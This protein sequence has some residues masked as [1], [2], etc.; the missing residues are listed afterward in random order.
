M[1]DRYSRQERFG[2]IGTPG[3]EALGSAKA[4]ICG[5]GA[6][7]TAGAELLVRAGVGHVVLIDRDY[8]ELSNLQRQFLFTEEDARQALPKAVAAERHLRLRNSA[9]RVTGIVDDLCSQNA[10]D[11][12]EG[13]NLI[14]DATDNFETRYLINDYSVEQGM[15]WI[16]AAAVGSYGITMPIIPELTPCF[17]CIYPQ[18]PSGTQPTCETAGVLGPVT[19]A[20]ASIA[21]AGALQIL[22]GNRA[23]IRQV[24]NTLDV[25]YG[26]I[27]EIRMPER[28][29]ECACCGHRNFDWLQGDRDEPVSLCG[30]NAVQIHTR[31]K[32]VDLEELTERLQRSG[33][34]RSNGFA[35]RF[36]NGSYE[37]TVFTDGRAIIKGTTDPGIARSLYSRWIG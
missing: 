32:S 9:V 18:P 6:L 36:V 15:P 2:P 11:L 20:V 29:P 16:Y 24:I 28:D 30:R 37:L 17:R 8:V 34:V 3:Q 10:R 19:A 12:F 1:D 7:G 21:A 26:P 14:F 33:E 22:S 4:V 13:A 5:C 27:R 23:S 35:L 25:W 31:G